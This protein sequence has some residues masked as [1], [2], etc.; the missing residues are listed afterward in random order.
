MKRLTS[1]A[2]ALALAAAA[3]PA[4]AHGFRLGALAI[5]HPYARATAP[6]QPIGGGYLKLD[7]Q[8]PADDRLLG[9]SAA[10][11]AERV[12]LHTMAMEGDVM[13]MRSLGAIDLPAGRSVELKPGGTHLMLVGLKA[14]LKAGDKFP[15][16]LRFERAG[17]VEV[18][19]NVEAA[20]AAAERHGAGH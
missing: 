1:L 16:T 18:V 12:E 5:G 10:A 19:V 13:R 20:G 2:A 17:Q 15:L 8:G 11:V 7:N 9:A 6:G 4:Q 14:P 3:F